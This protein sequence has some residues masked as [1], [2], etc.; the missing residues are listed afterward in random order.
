[1]HGCLCLF[2][3]I[4]KSTIIIVALSSLGFSRR[5]SVFWLTV[6]TFDA[7][8]ILI[9]RWFV[10]RFGD[11]VEAFA[12]F[13]TFAGPHRGRGQAP[14]A[15]PDHRDIHRVFTSRGIRPDDQSL[16]S[17]YPAESARCI[18]T[19]L[20]PRVLFELF[21]APFVSSI[22]VLVRN[23]E[24]PV[25]R[26][27]PHFFSPYLNFFTSIFAWSRW[28]HYFNFKSDSAWRVTRL[29]PFN[30]LYRHIKSF[31]ICC[32]IDQ[33]QHVSIL[34]RWVEINSCI[35]FFFDSY[36]VLQT[37][38]LQTPLQIYN[39]DPRNF[40]SFGPISLA[41]PRKTRCRNRESSAL[42]EPHQNL[43]LSSWQRC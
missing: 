35:R 3:V 22:R 6:L 28:H 9:G 32:I 8:L 41:G 13:R 34:T 1:V 40:R 15:P 26:L 20:S 21:Q 39:E 37:F 2:L 18:T 19:S 4:N 38:C 42:L 27:W 7:L 23:N 36:I 30:Y 17:K 25:T 33:L 43:D 12:H 10:S 5:V 24:P 11:H 14:E 16:G 29:P 31:Q